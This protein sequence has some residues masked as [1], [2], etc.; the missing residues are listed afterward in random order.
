VVADSYS[1]TASRTGAIKITLPTAGIG[2]SD[3]MS[4]EV[5][6]FEYSIGK[7]FKVYVS[8]Y[9]YQAAGL[10]TWVNETAYIV[11][12]PDTENYTV[13]FGHDGT[14]HCIF[15]GELADTWA[16]P[17][18]QV[19]NFRSGFTTTL[20]TY[21]S[22]WSISW[23]ASAFPADIQATYS[24]ITHG[25]GLMTTNGGYTMGGSY[26][27]ADSVQTKWGTGDDFRIY[28]DGANSWN[29]NYTGLFYQYQQANAG[30]RFYTNATLRMDLAST[31]E[32]QYYGAGVQVRNGAYL[33]V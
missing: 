15:I 12:A 11:G 19:M 16:Y 29:I 1:A 13:R 17:Q 30:M 9:C 33:R 28:H 8:G 23:E 4:F 20:A 18:V 6:V 27:H 32:L 22:G 14:A 7:S 10:N 31:G 2:P 21:A 24:N 3:M 5:G 26:G 25:Y